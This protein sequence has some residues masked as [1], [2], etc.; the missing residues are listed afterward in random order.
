MYKL[1]SLITK[2]ALGILL[3]CGL[4][5][6]DKLNVKRSEVAL[7]SSASSHK[8]FGPATHVPLEV[9]A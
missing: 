7:P 6:D 4:N 1:N 9:L 2:F 8:K 3:A 5:A